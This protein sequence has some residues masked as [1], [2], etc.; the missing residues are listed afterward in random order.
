MANQPEIAVVH[1]LLETHLRDVLV[2][3][4]QLR[5]ENAQMYQMLR[6]FVNDAWPMDVS[7][8]KE[9][10]RTFLAQYKEEGDGGSAA[11]AR[12]AWLH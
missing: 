6:L 2:A 7:T 3:N 10:A 8:A 11:G 5:R 12:H 1:E 4:A 9:R